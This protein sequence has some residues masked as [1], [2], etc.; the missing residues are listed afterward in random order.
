MQVSQKDSIFVEIVAQLRV[1][2]E[3]YGVTYQ[4]FPMQSRK[5]INL[6][7]KCIF[8]LESSTH[9]SCRSPRLNT[10]NT[11]KSARPKE[12]HKEVVSEK[13]R[14]MSERNLPPPPDS[15]LQSLFE[16]NARLLPSIPPPQPQ[17]SNQ[18]REH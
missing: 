3:V 10:A 1:N 7:N 12:R 8:Y 11:T 16:A 18:V 5:C 2:S 13:E 15:M 9:Q 4:K 17:T 6:I 14:F